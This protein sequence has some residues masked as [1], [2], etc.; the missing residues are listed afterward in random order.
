MADDRRTPLRRI[1]VART[2]ILVALLIFALLAFAPLL[3]PFRI[4]F[5]G[6]LVIG[7]VALVASYLWPWLQRLLRRARR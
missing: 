2:A 6:V 4:L 1:S 5:R 7:V 3:G